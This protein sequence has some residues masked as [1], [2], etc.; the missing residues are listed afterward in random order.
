M[1]N[2]F[3]Y[4]TL[5][6]ENVQIKN[7][8][9]SLSGTLDILQGYRLED[10]V[11]TDTFVLKTSQKKYH[12]IIFFQIAFKTKSKEQYLKLLHQSY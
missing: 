9:R 4:G 3:S 6:Q 1:E 7:F 10:L 12:P 2:L 11:I 8:G 5:Q